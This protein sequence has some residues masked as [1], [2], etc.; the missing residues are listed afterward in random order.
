MNHRISRTLGLG[1]E[2]Y[3]FDSPLYLTKSLLA[4]A[5][6]YLI[7]RQFPIANLD[8]ISVL[9]G[10]MYNLEPLNRLGIR[11]AISQVL[12]SII[13]A[14][15]TGILVLAFGVNVFSISIGMVLTLYVCLKINWRLVSPVAIFTSI[16]MTQYLQLNEAGLPSIWLTFRLRIMALS[17]G[18]LIALFYNYIFSNLYYKKFAEKRLQYANEQVLNGLKYTTQV[19]QQVLPR[20]KRGYIQLFSQQ[21]S[22]LD[23][24]YSNIESLKTEF[25]L[26]KKENKLSEL[27]KLQEIA[28]LYRDINHLTYDLNFLLESTPDVKLDKELEL[29]LEEVIIVLESID[30]TNSI[31]PPLH[32]LKVEKH[33][34]DLGN[35]FAERIN[36]ICE[37][38][39]LVVEKLQD[40]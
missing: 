25:T 20:G 24:I 27:K 11:S 14:A 30:Y 36:K 2:A 21:M 33:Y 13:G 26:L 4:I 1:Q 19:F 37:K 16:Y 18:I 40:L 23:L 8:M 9:L 38:V 5:T 39:N 22:D 3:L 34:L 7:G 15:A 29:L 6:G 12:A 10:V 32:E 28:Q 31:V 17:L 35:S